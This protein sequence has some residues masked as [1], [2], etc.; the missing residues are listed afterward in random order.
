MSKPAPTSHRPS[1]NNRLIIFTYRHLVRYWQFLARE[2]W[3]R[4]APTARIVW[5]ADAMWRSG[6][7]LQCPQVWTPCTHMMWLWMCLGQHS[8]WGQMAGHNAIGTEVEHVIWCGSGAATP[9]WHLLMDHLVAYKIIIKRITASIHAARVCTLHALM[10]IAG[11]S[12][13]WNVSLPKIVQVWV[14]CYAVLHALWIY[15][16][17]IFVFSSVC[18]GLLLYIY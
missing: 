3:W 11:T 17:N 13:T 18:C 4:A 5:R 2:Q 12:S 10:R 16:W 6:Q 1:T 8:S 9:I 15:F 7:R 14:T